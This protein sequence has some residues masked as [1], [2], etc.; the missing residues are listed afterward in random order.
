MYINNEERKAKIG[1]ISVSASR[2]NSIKL[3]FTYPKG[4]RNDINISTN[5]D[6]GW[7]KALRVAQ[8]INADIELGQFDSTLAKYS[9]KRSQALEI[10]QKEP[11]I[12]E[13]WE[14]YKELN[15]SRIAKTTQ[16]FLWRDCDRY[17]SKIDD[18]LLEL[19]KAQE[20]LAHLQTKYA[21]STIA[22]LFRSCFNPA[23][24]LAVE[25]ELISK[26]PF[27]KIRI[28]QPQK[29]P[30]EC[31]EPQEIREII[32]A[33]YNDRYSPKTSGYSHS[34][35]AHYVELL[36]LTGA[37]PEEVVA[38]TWDDIKCKGGNT[39]IRFSKAYSKGILLSHT[40]THEIRL[41]KCNKQLT[42]LVNS[43][44]RSGVNN[45]VLNAV[46]GGYINH[47]NFR[48]DN[49][50]VVLKGLVR[51]DKVHKYLRPYALRHSFVTRLIR[52]GTDI[53]TVA[54]LSGHSVKT[55][56]AHY[57]VSRDDF[58]LPEL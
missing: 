8:I 33:F 39:Y 56:L 47:S 19:S 2:D 6:E 52:E 30:P 3:R 17:L 27:K 54:S 24:N 23:I 31:F 20:F 40:K 58:D 53:K 46:R 14:R 57:L 4:K 21:V 36:A 25:A 12:K 35:Y 7:V 32:K 1:K 29:K 15:K 16:K 38:L 26:N 9:L 55:L 48:D 22:T 45:L 49:W 51:D 37:R 10:A 11:N 28:P 44:K 13:I 5:T 43:I 41:F 42:R 18:E 34:H 50:K